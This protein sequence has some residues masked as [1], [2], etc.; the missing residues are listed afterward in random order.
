MRLS[1][2]PSLSNSQTSSFVESTPSQTSNAPSSKD[3][4]QLSLHD[5]HGEII[6]LSA[7]THS[8]PSIR[9][10]RDPEDDAR[11]IQRD[12]FPIGLWTRDP[13]AQSHLPKLSVQSTK[14]KGYDND[15]GDTDIGYGQKRTAAGEVKSATGSL[16]TSPEA[17]SRRSHSKTV[18]VNSNSS[19]IGEVYKS[20]IHPY[21]DI[22]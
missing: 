17:T 21:R 8:T 6:P 22:F 11:I 1:E 20:A 12:I 10:A 18:S 16:P 9:Q 13:Q 3:T 7:S 4:S 15:V 5:S 19:Q 14:I 2:P